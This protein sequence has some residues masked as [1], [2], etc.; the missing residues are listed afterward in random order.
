MYRYDVSQILVDE[1]DGFES[2]ILALNKP[3]DEGEV[4]V[5]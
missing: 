2:V 5:E 3:A 1:A 4:E